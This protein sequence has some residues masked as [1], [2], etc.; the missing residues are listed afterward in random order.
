MRR[1]KLSG[2]RNIYESEKNHNILQDRL[3]GFPLREPYISCLWQVCAMSV[4]M[5]TL[6]LSEG[7]GMSYSCV[8]VRGCVKDKGER[9]IWRQPSPSV[10]CITVV[11]SH[12]P[13][14]ALW[15]FHQSVTSHL[16]THLSGL[17][18]V[19]KPRVPLTLRWPCTSFTAFSRLISWLCEK[20]T[21][22]K[23]VW[24]QV[25]TLSLFCLS[26][27]QSIKYI[28]PHKHGYCQT[29]MAETQRLFL[30]LNTIWQ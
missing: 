10:F 6:R 28:H 27:P 9:E 4:Y 1:G 2:W 25:V 3:N 26:C 7:L 8:C 29:Q 22:R 11:G 13:S 12:Y 16:F 17:Y 21:G 24:L 5:C 23:N 18:H 15:E 30:Y 14:W 20:H 19:E